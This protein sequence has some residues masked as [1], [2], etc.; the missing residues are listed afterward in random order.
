MTMYKKASELCMIRPILKSTD[1]MKIALL[2]WVD[3]ELARIKRK[4]SRI[5][6]GKRNAQSARETGRR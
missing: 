1:R 4:Q 5:R 2:V 6:K 3:A